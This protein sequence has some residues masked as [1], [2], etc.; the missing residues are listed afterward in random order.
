M[1]ENQTRP[2]CPL[3]F[4]QQKSVKR[5]IRLNSSGNGTKGEAW[6]KQ[7]HKLFVQPSSDILLS[8]QSVEIVLT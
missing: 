3:Y 5:N 2:P 7:L 1:V 8:K 4:G 6:L